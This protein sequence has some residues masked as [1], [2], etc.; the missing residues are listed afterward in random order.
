MTEYRSSLHSTLLH[1]TSD[2]AQAMQV[3]FAAVPNC[4]KLLLRIVDTRQASG[5]YEKIANGVSRNYRHVYPSLMKC[6]L[7]TIFYLKVN[8]LLLIYFMM[9]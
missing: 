6:I 2:T 5:V 4:V 7:R 3:R 8:L 1:F 9:D